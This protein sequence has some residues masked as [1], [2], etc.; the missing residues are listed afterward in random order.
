MKMNSCQHSS[1]VVDYIL[2]LLKPEELLEF[3]THL[4]SCTVCRQ[5]MKLE[6]MLTDEFEK[7]MNPGEIEQI[8]LAKLRLRREMNKGFSWGYAVRGVAYGVAAAILGIVIIPPLLSALI[9]VLNQVIP[10]IPQPEF[11]WVESFGS[12][13]AVFSNLYVVGGIGIAALIGSIIYTI[14]VMKAQFSLSQ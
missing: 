12:V 9:R 1:K 7:G 2:G 5:E 10:R 13:A 3:E 4:E 6:A 14:Y 11:G 8:V